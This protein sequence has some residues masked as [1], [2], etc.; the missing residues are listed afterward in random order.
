MHAERRDALE[1]E[2]LVQRHRGLLSVARL[3]A[4]GLESEAR[5]TRSRNTSMARAIPVRRAARETYMRRIST[6][7]SSMGRSA[8]QPTGVPSKQAST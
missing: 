2:G 5:A 8:P 4:H 6:H 3:E 7:K 1:P